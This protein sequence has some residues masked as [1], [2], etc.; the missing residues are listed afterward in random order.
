MAHLGG[1]AAPAQPWGAPWAGGAG[2]DPRARPGHEATSAQRQ[3]RD[4]T[5]EL[6]PK[7]QGVYTHL[8]I[9]QFIYIYLAMFYID[10]YIYIYL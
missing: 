7:S 10:I 9:D 6:K 5:R 2:W 3:L 4:Q 1:A 8:H